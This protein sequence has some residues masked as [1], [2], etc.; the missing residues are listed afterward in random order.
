MTKRSPKKRGLTAKQQAF[1]DAY[2][3]TLCATEAAREARYKHPDRQG[4]RLLR[5]VVVKS[6]IDFRMAQRA[7]EAELTQD[8]VLAELMKIG[9]SNI[10]DFVT[11]GG[12]VLDLCDLSR[13]QCAAIKE[14]T[15]ET[16]RE[17]KGETA[18][19][20]TRT[21]IGFW[22]KRQTLIDL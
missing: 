8:M 12:S 22:D 15:V 11:P 4:P 18:E 1:V 17:G 2:L 5:N 10:H 6:E 21:K 16:K 3:I 19:T 14:I 20:V 7:E 9:F 13:D